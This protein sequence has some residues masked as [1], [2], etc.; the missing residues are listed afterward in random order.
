MPCPNTKY[1]L[2]EATIFS[3][4]PKTLILSFIAKNPGLKTHEIKVGIKR[5]SLGM[6]LR[7]LTDKGALIRMQDGGWQIST[8]YII[9]E[10]VKNLTPIDI[11]EKYIREMIYC[12]GN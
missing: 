2:T 11:A 1:Y 8:N 6:H 5:A 7:N 12:S 10:P 9:E 4:E 3:M